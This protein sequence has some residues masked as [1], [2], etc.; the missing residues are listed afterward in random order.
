MTEAP[1]PLILSP[2]VLEG[3][4]ELDGAVDAL[5]ALVDDALPP[6]DVRDALQGEWLGHPVHPVLTD[7]AIGFWTSAFVLDLVPVKRLRAAADVF[8][9]LGL[10]AAVPTVLTGLADWSRLPR[11]RQRVGVVHA[12]SNAVASGFYAWSLAARVRGRR[13]RGITLGMLGAGA[14]TVGGYLGGHLAFPPSEV[15]PARSDDDQTGA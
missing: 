10:A 5:R 8:V 9:A 3:V 7:L 6:G 14:A 15:V 13:A 2:T 11:E 1:A 4:A 12:G